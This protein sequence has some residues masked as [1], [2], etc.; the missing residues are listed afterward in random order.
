MSTLSFRPA[1]SHPT[2]RARLAVLALPF[3]A[4][5]A[6]VACAGGGASTRV[7]AAHA[8]APP[9]VTV[10]A[11]AGNPWL[12]DTVS[13]AEFARVTGRSATKV[14]IGSGD[15]GLT[16]LREVS[17]IYVDAFDPAQVFARGTID[18][19]VAGDARAAA[20][21][22]GRVKRSFT[23]VSDVRGV[24]D[25]AFAGSPGGTGDGAATGLLVMRGP[26]LLYV[27]V[28]G[29]GSATLRVTTGLATL[30]LERVVAR[31]G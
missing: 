24:G 5:L 3:W 26:V 8:P 15:D 1:A 6:L 10:A 20:V 29:E 18:F 19:E 14:A 27:S 28:G 25:A 11:T 23:D 22:F 17:C 9:P 13:P 21:I 2:P 16:G 12:C 7:A 31:S 30:A 4:A